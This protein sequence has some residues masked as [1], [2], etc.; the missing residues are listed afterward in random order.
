MSIQSKTTVDADARRAR[1][2]IL[3]AAA[4]WSLAGVFIKALAL[5][6]LTIVFYRSLFAALFFAPLVKSRAVKFP[7]PLFVSALS[8]TAAVS[9]FVAANKLTSAANAIVL[10]YT[11]PIF[12]FIFARF[13]FRERISRPNLVALGACTLGVVVIYAGSAEL[14]DVQGVGVALFSGFCFAVYMTNLRFLKNTD[15]RWLTF[16]NN[17]ACSLLLLPWVAGALALDLVDAAILVVMGVAQLGVPYFLFSKG[18]E[19]ISLQE[20]SL[21]VLVEPVLNPI[22]VAAAYGE[23]PGAAT[24]IGGGLILSSLAARYGFSARNL[25]RR[26]PSLRSG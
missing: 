26:D 15:A 9:A 25:F 10:Q 22:W 11:A 18:V 14:R 6:P 1:L 5:N 3:G 8:Y 21:I 19:K 12:V 13:L 4:L 17:A 7:A 16:A 20:A 2:C 23:V 24:L